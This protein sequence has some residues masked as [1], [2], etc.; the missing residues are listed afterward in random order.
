MTSAAKATATLPTGG[1]GRKA[2]LK[3]CW[4]VFSVKAPNCF[5]WRWIPE[6]PPWL[7][8]ANR[9]TRTTTAFQGLSSGSEAVQPAADGYQV[10]IV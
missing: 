3:E 1:N 2:G 4:G 9:V 5:Q 8:F 7:P 6:E 10:T